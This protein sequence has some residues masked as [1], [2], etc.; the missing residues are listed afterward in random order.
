M[1]LNYAESMFD[2]SKMMTKYPKTPSPVVQTK[3]NRFVFKKTVKSGNAKGNLYMLKFPKW[4][5]TDAKQLKRCRRWEII[6][7]PGALWNCP[8]KKMKMFVEGCQVVNTTGMKNDVG[9]NTSNSLG[10]YT[11]SISKFFE[12][13]VYNKSM[14]NQDSSTK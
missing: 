9:I 12:N 8:S 3:N 7:G 4:S 6:R 1:Q 5:K 2:R 13:Q 14:Q 11:H 10:F